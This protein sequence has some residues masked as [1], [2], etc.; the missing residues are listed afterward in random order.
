MRCGFLALLSMLLIGCEKVPEDLWGPPGPC[1]TEEH[2]FPDD[3]GKWQRT[4]WEQIDAANGAS[5]DVVFIGDSITHGWLNSPAWAQFSGNSVNFAIGGDNSAHVLWRLQSGLL[6]HISEP[7]VIVLLIGFNDYATGRP[8]SHVIH[9]IGCVIDE[10]HARA[11]HAKILQVGVLPSGYHRDAESRQF[12]ERVNPALEADAQSKGVTFMSLWEEFQN[13]DGSLVSGITSD[14]VH[15]T[16]A[17]YA[18]WASKMSPVL[19][20]L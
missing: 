1:A 5:P 16:N 7:R 2:V 18:V 10:L 8:P 4:H 11:P 9:R 13:P 20:G 19:A 17:G 15:P 14:G 12:F 6:D 3:P